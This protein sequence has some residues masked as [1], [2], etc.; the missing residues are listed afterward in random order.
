MTNPNTAMK[1]LIIL[2]ALLLSVPALAQTE[3][4]EFPR[5]RKGNFLERIDSVRSAILIEELELTEQETADFLP[6]YREYSRQIRQ[7]QIDMVFDRRRARF[8]DGDTAEELTEA[9]ALAALREKRAAEAKLA[10]LRREAEEAY[11]E[12]LPAQKVFRLEAAE[13]A[14]REKL[15]E[16]RSERN[17]PARPGDRERLNRRN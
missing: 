8:S 11:L 9:E 2:F 17:R 14:F 12:V 3:R 10:N 7:L 6:V 15:L 1:N 5:A 16:L 4:P 13:R